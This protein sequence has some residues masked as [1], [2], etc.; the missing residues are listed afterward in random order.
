MAKQLIHYPYYFFWCEVAQ[1]VI[2]VLQAFAAF[3]GTE[4]STV[5]L[6]VHNLIMH[7]FH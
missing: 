3:F 6:G 5:H 7:R 2:F 1:N 4:I